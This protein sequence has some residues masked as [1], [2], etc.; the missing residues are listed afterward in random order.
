VFT[1]SLSGSCEFLCLCD[2]I[3]PETVQC[4][5]CDE[6]T[7]NRVFL[8]T[9]QTAVVVSH[10][11]DRVTVRAKAERPREDILVVLETNFPGWHVAVDG[12]PS[13]VVAVGDFLGVEA[14]F[15]E[16]AYTF[17]FQPPEFDLGLLISCA[18]LVLISVHLLFR[19]E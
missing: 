6:A 2:P 17:W 3:L 13:H 5:S 14:E 11:I 16:H 12:I 19:R 9:T 1:T 8:L 4:L 10:E 15:G 18:T 7:F